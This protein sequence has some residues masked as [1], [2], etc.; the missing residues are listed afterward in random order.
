[1]RTYT[2][3]S[4]HARPCDLCGRAILPGDRVKSWPWL[5]DEPPATSNIMRVHATCEAIQVREK[6]EEWNLGEGFE[7]YA[8]CDAPEKPR[9]PDCLFHEAMDALDEARAE[10]VRQ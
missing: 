5:G 4:K 10:A 3:K 1:M 7:C 8:G 2:A 6:I 9:D